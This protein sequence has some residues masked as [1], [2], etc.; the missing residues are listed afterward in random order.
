MINDDY[1][2]KERPVTVRNSQ[3]NAVVERVHKAIG[4][5]IQIFELENN[6]FYEENTLEE[7]LS[8]TA[9]AVRSAFHTGLQSI[10]G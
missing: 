5:I 7:I 1:E 6:Y 8:G 4:N 2:I 9:F 10:L 3:A